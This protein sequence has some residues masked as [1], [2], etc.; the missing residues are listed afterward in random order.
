MPEIRELRARPEE[1]RR[2]KQLV[3]DLS[4][5]GTTLQESLQRR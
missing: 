1:T 4:L 2:L 3:A 5:D